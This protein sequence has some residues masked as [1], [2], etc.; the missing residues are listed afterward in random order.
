MAICRI[1]RCTDDDCSL[2]IERTGK[3]C[4]WV[5]PDL[6]SACVFSSVPSDFE[7]ND[8]II[9]ESMPHDL[10]EFITHIVNQYGGKIYKK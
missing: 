4:Y 7:E 3:P 8:A 6:C 2:C 5:E 10:K 1:C 9:S